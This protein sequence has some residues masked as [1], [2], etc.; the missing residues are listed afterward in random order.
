MLRSEAERA[1]G[2]PVRSFDRREN[3]VVIVTLVFETGDEQITAEFVE[4]VLVRY[5]VASK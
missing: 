2:R 4:D 3:S 5:S 1:F